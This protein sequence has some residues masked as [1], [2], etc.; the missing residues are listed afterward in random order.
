MPLLFSRLTDTD[1]RSWLLKL[2][3][4]LLG[5]MLL[6]GSTWLY[7]GYRVRLLDQQLH[8]SPATSSPVPSDS[9]SV[10]TH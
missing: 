2:L 1:R 5:A 10:R 3:A 6:L 7:Y 4:L 8:Q 9:S